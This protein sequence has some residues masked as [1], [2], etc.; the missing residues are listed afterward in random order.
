MRS[1][2]W[3][4]AVPILGSVFFLDHNWNDKWTTAVGFSHQDNDNTDG[5]A[6][7]AFKSGMYAL[8]NLLFTRCPA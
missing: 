8:G 4:K 3:G 1:R 5:Q 7:D 2:R 6:P